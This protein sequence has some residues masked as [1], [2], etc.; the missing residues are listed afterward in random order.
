VFF[1]IA[2]A[3][4]GVRFFRVVANHPIPAPP[5]SNRRE[6][7]AM[8]NKDEST[9]EMDLAALDLLVELSNDHATAATLDDVAGQGR[10]LAGR[11]QSRILASVVS[12]RESHG[13]RAVL[14]R[15]RRSAYARTAKVKKENGAR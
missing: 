12:D 15:G 7:R 3:S 11:T 1:L 5:K 2:K 14:L 9:I 10:A 8:R 4:W 6:G 13:T